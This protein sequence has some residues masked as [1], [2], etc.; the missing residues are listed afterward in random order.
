ME[1]HLTSYSIVNVY[2]CKSYIW[3][4]CFHV[5]PT[6]WY[7][8]VYILQRV[9][10]GVCTMYIVQERYMCVYTLEYVHCTGKIQVCAY[11]EQYNVYKEDACL[12]IL[13][14]M[15]MCVQEKYMC[16]YTLEYVHV[17]VQGR[18]MHMCVYKEDTCVCVYTLNPYCVSLLVII[19]NSLI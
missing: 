4:T 13:Q 10:K 18:Y 16:V 3:Y 6:V 19:I 8:C 7:M 12:C 17:Y 1:I 14:S 15:Y 11:S 9:C 5:F 2:A